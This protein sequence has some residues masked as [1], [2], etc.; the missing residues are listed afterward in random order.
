MEQKTDKSREQ[1]E[2]GAALAVYD[3]IALGLADLR[4]K[5]QNVAYAVA[6][7][8][9][10]A[11]ARA[12][13]KELVTLR[14]R[15]DGSYKEWNTHMLAAQR[16]MRAKA[17]ELEKEILALEK[18]IDDQIKADE[19]RRKKEKEEKERIERERLAAIERERLEAERLRIEAERAAERERLA[20]ERAE[21]MAKVEA[22]RAKMAAE[23]AEAERIAAIE[24]AEAEKIAEVERKRVA[25]ERAEMELANKVLA[26]AMAAKEAR[27]KEF[28]LAEAARIA[29][30]KRSED[31]KLA[32][33]EERRVEA[34]RVEAAHQAILVPAVAPPTSGEV[35]DLLRELL[36]WVDYSGNQHTEIYQKTKHMIE[37]MDVPAEW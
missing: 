25:A 6:T 2:V 7:T 24:R 32:A 14:G 16:A 34:L 4:Q 13:R 10:N 18:P 19:E 12:A 33:E 35:L 11:E 3:P 5:Y 28:E 17:A 31:A 29:E 9:G 36:D 27:I 23:R 1:A 15:V 26:E 22:E 30:E 20:A 37:R 8:A 21:L